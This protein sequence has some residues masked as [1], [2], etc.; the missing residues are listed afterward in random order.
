MHTLERT[1]NVCELRYDRYLR[2]EDAY[3][4][5]ARYRTLHLVETLC[6][7]AL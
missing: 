2:S 1:A 4:L 3:S 7:V 5:P 6:L